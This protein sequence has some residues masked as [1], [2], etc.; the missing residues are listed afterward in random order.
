M[1]IRS[2][3]IAAV[4]LLSLGACTPAQTEAPPRESSAPARVAAGTVSVDSAQLIRDIRVLSA[5]SME[6]RRTGT[7]GS[8]RA[9]AYL[10]Q[11]FREVGLTAFGGGYEQAFAFTGRD[12]TAYQGVNLVGYV[13]GTEHPERYLVITAHYDHLGVRN[14]QIYNGADDNASGT[15][16]LLA[17]AAEMRRQPPRHSVIFAALDAEELG[18]QGARAFVASPPVPL[19]RIVLNVNMDMISRNDRNELY[20]AGTYHYPALRPFVERVAARSGVNLLMGHDRPDLPPGDDW[21]MS[22]DHGAFHQVG[23]PFVYFGV[24]DHPD[25]H[26]PTDTFENIQPGFFVRAARTVLDF[27][28]EVDAALAG[29]RPGATALSGYRL[30]PSPPVTAGA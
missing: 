28:R 17:F 24:E 15:S 22:S 29:R 19:E 3:A 20:A 14:G 5:D 1:T 9:R 12:G 10:L 30:T 7:P 27:V 25:Y 4:T 18:L 21:T 11:R 6:G 2:A 23:I 26:Q 8:A 13:R 16:A